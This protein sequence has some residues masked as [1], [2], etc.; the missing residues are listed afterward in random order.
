MLNFKPGQRVYH[1][2]QMHHPGVIIELKR[3]KSKQWLTEGTAQDRLMAV[4]KHDNGEVS[5]FW[6]SD[7]RKED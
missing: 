6:A 7:L 1:Y 4:V 5:N 3:V 2:L